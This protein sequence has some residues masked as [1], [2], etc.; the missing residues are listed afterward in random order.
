MTTEG[1]ITRALVILIV[2]L[3]AYNTWQVLTW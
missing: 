3:I 2:L 1:R